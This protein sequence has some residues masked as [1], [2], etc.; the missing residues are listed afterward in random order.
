MFLEPV[1]G[2]VAAAAEETRRSVEAD[3][4]LCDTRLVSRHSYESARQQAEEGERVVGREAADERKQLQLQEPAGLGGGGARGG[5]GAP[6][7][8]PASGRSRA[9]RRPR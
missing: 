3:C 9:G 1:E 7:R 4:A 8:W 2:T 6:R 5:R